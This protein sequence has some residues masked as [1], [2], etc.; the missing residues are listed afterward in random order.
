MSFDSQA[1]SAAE[2]IFDVFGVPAVVTH[3]A[4]PVST[5]VVMDK[6]LETSGED[7]ES[8]VTETGKKAS[9]LTT[10]VPALTRDDQVNIGGTLYSVRQKVFDDGVVH[11]WR[12]RAV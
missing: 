4:I 1:V 8:S 12:V 9:F 5:T 2:T 7:F 3:A 6:D 11:A 10:E